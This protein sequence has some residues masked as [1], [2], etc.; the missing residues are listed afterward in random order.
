MDV[1]A[2]I[3]AIL[4]PMPAPGS[5]QPEEAFS[6]ACEAVDARRKKTIA[7][8]EAAWDAVDAEPLLHALTDARIRKEQ[9]E[10]EIRCLLAYGREFTRPR[11][12]TLES[13]AAAAGMSISGVRT[14]YDQDQVAVVT[15]SIGR[16][17]CKWR[18]TD[19]S[20]PPDDA[21]ARA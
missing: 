7:E 11:P 5:V 17:S 18:I 20:D 8:L 2:E 13:L 15:H 6:D 3:A 16:P 1:I 9:A 14:A 21:L 19:P 12:Y 4:H 10:E